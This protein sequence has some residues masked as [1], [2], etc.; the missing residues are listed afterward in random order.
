M[1][2][3]S[4]S[5]ASLPPVFR[6]FARQWHSMFSAELPPLLRTV[7]VAGPGAGHWSVAVVRARAVAGTDARAEAILDVFER[8]LATALG[9]GAPHWPARLRRTAPAPHGID[10]PA[11]DPSQQL[12]LGV[13][14]DDTR[15]DAA[16]LF[17]LEAAFGPRSESPHAAE[18]RARVCS[19]AVTPTA[20]ERWRAGF[21]LM[22]PDAVA[23][24]EHHGAMRLLQRAFGEDGRVYP[25]DASMCAPMRP[26]AALDVLLAGLAVRAAL[27]RSGIMRDLEET[28][29]ERR[30]A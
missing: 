12:L 20:R 8:E 6:G 24:G 1:S 14:H 9:M 25:V 10:M 13:G 19:L 17:L 7:A 23:P 3:P 22:P 11:L 4:P 29:V 5:L 16:I 18:L 21:G 15:D 27:R 28:V 30:A 26:E 2:W